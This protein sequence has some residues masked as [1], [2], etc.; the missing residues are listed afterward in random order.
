MVGGR[1]D[2]PLPKVGDA[3]DWYAQIAQSFIKYGLDMAVKSTDPLVINF[4]LGTTEVS[5]EDMKG[6]LPLI[7]GFFKR[8]KSDE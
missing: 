6:L 1:R 4:S 7:L 8:G 5:K 2:R 3:A